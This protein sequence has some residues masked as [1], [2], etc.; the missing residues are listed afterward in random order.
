MTN[1]AA[2]PRRYGVLGAGA[3]GSVYG[4][5]L[6]QAGHPVLFGLRSDLAAGRAHGLSVESPWGDLTVP[7]DHLCGSPAELSGCDGLLIGLKSTANGLLPALLAQIT[8]APAWI[9]LLQNGLGGE[10][11]VAAA[12]SQAV[13]LGG[14]CD[15]ACSRVGPAR[16]K[17]YAYGLLR[18]APLQGTEAARS[19][20]AAVADDFSAAGVPVQNNT[21]LVSMRWHKLVWNMAFSGLCTLSGLRTLELLGE[22][23]LRQRLLAVMQEVAAAATADGALLEADL[24]ASY[25][26]KT[27]A[28]ISYAPSMQLDAEAGRPLELEA[29]YREPLRRAQRHGVAMPETTRLLHEL[30][31]L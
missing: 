22:P 24:I 6:W 15:I 2:E 13:L 7:P 28:M 16:V 12:M 20:C 27:E 10:E 23:T 3:I 8:P 17:H 9:V 31:N 19:A 11:L 4:S 25:L 18:L 5:R 29:I 30:D 1:R 14:I 26:T 21:S